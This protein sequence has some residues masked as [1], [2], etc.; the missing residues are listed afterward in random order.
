[1]R[2]LL[3]SFVGLFVSLPLCGM[4]PLPHKYKIGEKL[5]P[6]LYEYRVTGNSAGKTGSL[7]FTYFPQPVVVIYSREMNDSVVRLLKKVDEKTGQ[8]RTKPL[9]PNP[10]RLGSYLVHV[11]DSQDREKD[12][13][14]LAEKEKI[15][16]TV[17]AM[18][19]INKD[20]LAEEAKKG[21]STRLDLQAKLGEAE[22]TV[23]L[24]APR[25]IVKAGYA[26]RKGELTDKEI[27][28][29]LADVTK[30][31]P[32]KENPKDPS[33]SILGT[34]AALDRHLAIG[35]LYQPVHGVRI[36]DGVVQFR[37]E[38]ERLMGRAIHADHAAI[39]HQQRWKD[40][41]T[42]F[43]KVTFAGD[44]LTFEWDI[45]EWRKQAGAL[46]IDDNRLP[47]KG[48]IRVV[49]TLKGDRLIGQWGM[50]LADGSEPYRGEW[51]AVRVPEPGPL[52]L[53]GG[54][55]QDLPDDF[56]ERFFQ[57]AGGAKAKIVVIPTAV[58]NPMD[59]KPEEYLK[60]PRDVTPASFQVLHTRDPKQA[61]D[62][63]FVKPLTEA[64]AV[65]I[66]NGHR[67]RIIDAYRGTLVE[68][69]LKKLHARGGLIAG[70]GTGAIV[71]GE[72]ISHRP[73]ADQLTEHGFGLLPGMLLDEGGRKGQLTKAIDANPAY[74]GL[75]IE[76]EMT[77]EIHGNRMSVIGK[78]TLTLRFAMGA[79]Q[80]AKSETLKGGETRDL[81]ELRRAATERAKG[82]AKKE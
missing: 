9:P 29:I 53:Y 73:G 35:S 78:G 36:R 30:I 45:A 77:V 65:F 5:S 54:R 22:T 59:T 14:A 51:E 49:A 27:D 39:T 6:H 20:T 40:G 69:E 31:L 61:N 11:C 33:A 56:R 60:R 48:T 71:L 16:H 57:L 23:L 38:G 58:G 66:T 82:A 74:S 55:H 46:A 25:G 70:A 8:Y 13:K 10:Q 68:K 21:G 32:T 4:E 7:T 26:Y 44:K 41:C 63:A 79:G 43:R 75:T 2:S 3:I 24:T 72:R 62:P 15:T 67:H 50:F 80:E 81:G 34:W 37:L 1:M 42:E 18:M 76:N 19:V 17:L 47:N 12:W 52:L 64:T 28:R